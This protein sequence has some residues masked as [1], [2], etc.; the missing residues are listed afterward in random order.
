MFSFRRIILIQ[1]GEFLFFSETP[2]KADVIVV[3]RGG[4]YDRFIQA[5]ELYRQGLADKVL[6]PTSLSDELPE[7]LK[8][9]NVL[10]PTSHEVIE[11]ILMQMGIPEEKIILSVS[12]PGGGTIAEAIRTKNELRGMGVNSFIVVTSWYH[13]KRVRDVYL[14][15][16]TGSNMKFWVVVS[17]F[18]KSN[19]GNWWQ[20]RYVTRNVIFEYM[21]I[22]FFARTYNVKFHDDPYYDSNI[23]KTTVN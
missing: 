16:F 8:R 15:H 23:K 10:V 21:R 18:S 2:K 19:V 14:K 22:I 13:S 4:A 5:A 9:N 7:E 11:S 20:Y 17:K 1:I 12:K 3:L 6:I